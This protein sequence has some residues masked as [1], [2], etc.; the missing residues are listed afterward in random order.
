MI[1]VSSPNAGQW[2]PPPI[3]SSPGSHSDPPPACAPDATARSCV[4]TTKE[5]SFVGVTAACAKHEE[6]GKSRHHIRV[7]QPFSHAPQS[8]QQHFETSFDLDVAP[9][10]PPPCEILHAPRF[11]CEASMPE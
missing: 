8:Q 2:A 10:I 7:A 9:T 11:A 1:N 6:Y 3:K 5:L 4:R